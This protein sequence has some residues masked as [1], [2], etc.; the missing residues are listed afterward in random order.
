MRTIG[1]WAAETFPSQTAVGK[2][3]HLSE[4]IQE[5]IEALESGETEAIES[6]YADCAIL[7]MDVARTAGMD[8]AQVD[9]AIERKMDVNRSRKWGKPDSNGVCHH[10]K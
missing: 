2:L 6:E 9:R 8:A 5:L 10:I 3:C 4:E 1:D 7:L